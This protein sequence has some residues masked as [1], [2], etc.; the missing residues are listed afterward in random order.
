LKDAL[1]GPL[2]NVAHRLGFLPANSKTELVERYTELTKGLQ[3]LILSLDN[4]S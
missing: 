2:F 1:A 4:E 3:K